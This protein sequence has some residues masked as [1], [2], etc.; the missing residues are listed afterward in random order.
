MP[1][2]YRVGKVGRPYSIISRRGGRAVPSVTLPVKEGKVVNQDTPTLS[3]GTKS[4]A[5]IRLKFVGL[6]DFLVRSRG[7]RVIDFEIYE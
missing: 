1:E 3:N 7:Q 5:T 2:V 4:A 6:D